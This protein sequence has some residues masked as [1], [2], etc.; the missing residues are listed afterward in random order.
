MSVFRWVAK[1]LPA[2][3]RPTGSVVA[4]AGGFVSFPTGTVW[5][6]GMYRR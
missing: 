1:F 4:R 2:K 6:V 5:R 3:P